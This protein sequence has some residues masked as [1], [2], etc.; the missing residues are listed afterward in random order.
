MTEDRFHE[1]VRLH[2]IAA[3]NTLLLINDDRVFHEVDEAVRVI[4]RMHC[5]DQL[6]VVCSRSLRLEEVL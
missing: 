5:G 2:C 4:V 1:T 6:S 3:A